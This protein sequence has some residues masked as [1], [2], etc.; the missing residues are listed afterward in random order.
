MKLLSGAAIA[1]ILAAGFLQ[2]SAQTPPAAGNEGAGPPPANAVNVKGSE[3]FDAK[4][5]QCHDPAVER[6]PTKAGLAQRWPEDII[7]SLKT[8]LM[9]PMAAG[10]SEDDMKT[11]A[12]YLTG[13]QVGVNFA[14]AEEGKHTCPAAN[15]FKPAGASWNGWSP[16]KENTRVAVGSTIKAADVPKMKVKWSFAYQGGRYGQP[17]VVGNRVFVTSSSGMAYALDRDSG[18]VGWSFNAGTGVRVTMSVGKNPAAPSGYAAYFGDY[19]RNV[20]AVD[21][22]SGKELW[23]TNIEKHGRGV[24]TGA[25]TLYNDVLYVPVSS[26]EET[27]SSIDAYECCTFSGSVVAL[28]VK[29]GAQKWKSAVLPEPKPY[30]KSKAGAQMYGPAGAAI[31]SAPTIDPKKG[32]LYVATG[33]SYTE[34]KEDASDAVIAMDL[35]TG[36]IKWKHQVTEDDNFLTGCPPQR[37]AVNCPLPTGPDHDFGS[38]PIVKKTKAGKDIVLAGQKSGQ[39][40]AFDP[41]DG[42][43]LWQQRVGKGSALGGVEWGMAA[44]DDNIYVAINRS[45]PSLT[46]FR[47]TDGQQVWQVLAPEPG[48]CSFKGR[49]G[50]GYSAPPTLMNGIVFAPNQDGHLRAFEAKTG[51]PVW[52]Y[53]TA[54]QTY[55]TVN[56]VKG[57]RGGNLDATGITFAGGMAYLMA[58]F[59]GA[60]G[61]SGPD[62]VLL[63]F[64]VDGK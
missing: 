32:V 24:L 4:C 55:D 2:A 52:D 56:G 12:V 5:K 40:Y 61:S 43:I 49:C 47:L 13:R 25:P 54:G 62:N 36:A 51:K 16:D 15:T 63:A 17:T 27:I 57:Q 21:A 11:L 18:C 34:V 41:A 45:T 29:T 30:K 46:A 44:D 64:S 33:D 3:I 58:G 26:W 50:N 59:N 42:K 14:T 38:A 6:A 19:Q 10:M 39:V 31:W 20:R 8:G 7:A 37:P 22:N 28:D 35:K 9:A 48:Q 1:A 23:K 53:D 60:S